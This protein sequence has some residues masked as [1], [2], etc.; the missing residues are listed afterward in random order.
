MYS[1][2]EAPRMVRIGG[3]HFDRQAFIGYPR[4]MNDQSLVQ[5]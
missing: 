1:S 2:P 5:K 3:R 4:A